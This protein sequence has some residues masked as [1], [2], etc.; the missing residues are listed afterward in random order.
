MQIRCQR[1][2]KPF[3]ISKEIVVAA[4]NMMSEANMGHYNA[5]C[6]HCRRMNQIPRDEMVRQ[7]PEWKREETPVEEE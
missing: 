2:H 7:T 5:Q 4:L 1:C 3:A 6:P